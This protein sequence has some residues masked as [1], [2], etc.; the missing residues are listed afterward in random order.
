MIDD[1]VLITLV[2]LGGTFLDVARRV[3]LLYDNQI[4]AVEKMKDE[5]VVL[6]STV[7]DLQEEIEDLKEA[8]NEKDTKMKVLV[9]KS[10]VLYEKY[11]L[12]KTRL[13]DDL[14]E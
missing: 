11:Q 14:P 8:Q 10:R 7:R 9:S 3:L 1:S 13:A 5:A 4:R 12:L 2:A 6:R